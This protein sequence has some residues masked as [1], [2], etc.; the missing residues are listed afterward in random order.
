M[1]VQNK[2]C[3]MFSTPGMDSPFVVFFA[4][5]S[6]FVINPISDFLKKVHIRMTI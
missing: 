3:S 1:A 6:V 4:Y 5:H 2:D